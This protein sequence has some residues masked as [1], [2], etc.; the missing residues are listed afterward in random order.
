MQGCPYTTKELLKLSRLRRYSPIALRLR[1]VMFSVAGFTGDEIA[2]KLGVSTSFVDKWVKR[3]K[4]NSFEPDSLFDQPRT[5]RKSKLSDDQEKELLG[6]I[7]DTAGSAQTRMTA[8]QIM[9]LIRSRFQVNYSQSSIYPLLRRLNVVPADGMAKPRL[10][11]SRSG[12][13]RLS[14]SPVM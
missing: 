11:A 3:F 8:K 1:T 2:Q 10:T 7:E 4:E 5:G 13:S 9:D 12:A 14:R 6:L